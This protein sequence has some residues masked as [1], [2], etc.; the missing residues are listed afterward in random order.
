MTP[1]RHPARC[2][3][4]V[5]V[6]LVM[7]G[8][9]KPKPVRATRVHDSQNGF[10]FVPPAGWTS[11]GHH[12][13][14]FMTYTGPTEGS[15]TVNFNVV[16]GPHDGSSIE[17]C[18]RQVI[19]GYRK[20]FAGWELA[21]DGFV[22]I[23]GKKSYFIISSRSISGAHRVQSLQYFLIGRDG[24][25][26]YAMTFSAPAESFTRHRTVFEAAAMTARLD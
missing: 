7:A 10:S 9:S 23:D 17:Q 13:G 11:G 14:A 16:R 4:L 24:K 25:T 12:D 1:A 26:V 18:P 3:T 5:L 15:S 8:C 21:G 19:P 2:L 6:I 22:E 20:M